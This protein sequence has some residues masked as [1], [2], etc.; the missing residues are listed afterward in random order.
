MRIKDLFLLAFLLLFTVSAA[1]AQDSAVR[2]P[3]R[4]NGQWFQDFGGDFIQTG[5]AP[6][7]WDGRSWMKFGGFAAVT[8]GLMVFDE[9]IHTFLLDHDSPFITQQSEN[10]LNDMWSFQ[11]VLPAMGLTYT[12]AR[13][14]KKDRLAFTTLTAFRA[15]MVTTVFTGGFK[16]MFHRHRP[17]EHQPPDAYIWDGPSLSTDFL[18]FPS[19]HSSLSFAVAAVVAS[20]YSENKWVGG[21]AYGLA[22]LTA[23]SRIY[24]NK[25]WASD[26]LAGSVL[27]YAI[28]RFVHKRASG[29]MDAEKKKFSFAPAIMPGGGSGIVMTYKIGG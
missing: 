7:K 18:S 14:A 21:I 16:M 26:V 9:D 3:V 19:G 5:L 28:G 1:K 20:E 6:L 27:G 25:H 8:G 17:N 2:Y 15:F 12:A 29:R 24:G 13:I 23:I 10:L 11:Y 4:I 22:G